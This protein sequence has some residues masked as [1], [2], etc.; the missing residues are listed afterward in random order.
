[1]HRIAR[2]CLHSRNFSCS[3]KLRRSFDV[4]RSKKRSSR[5]VDVKLW[6]TGSI[7]C[8]MAPIQTCVSSMKSYKWSTRCRL[9]LLNCKIALS[10][11]RLWKCTLAIVQTWFKCKTW[12]SWFWTNG[13]AWY[14][15]YRRA[16]L[17][18]GDQLMMTRM[19]SMKVAKHQDRI[20]IAT[21]DANWTE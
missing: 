21:Y 7:R 20:S 17:K 15:R 6:L 4:F 3:R 2:A 10:S 13:V 11:S 18:Q 14:S 5:R 8:P 19:S 1:M 16:T 12:P 9:T